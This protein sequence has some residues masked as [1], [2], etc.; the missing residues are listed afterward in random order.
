MVSHQNY[1][2][3]YS[4][5][6]IS[7]RPKAPRPKA[8]DNTCYYK[9]LGTLPKLVRALLTAQRSGR[10]VFWRTSTRLCAESLGVPLEWSTHGSADLRDNEMTLPRMN[11]VLLYVLL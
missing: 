6:R 3:C 1:D 4:T 5:I 11:A 9:L 2:K 8:R 10:H 7:I